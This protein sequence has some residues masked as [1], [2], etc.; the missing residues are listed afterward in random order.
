[1]G[2]LNSMNGWRNN[3]KPY[4]FFAL[5]SDDQHGSKHHTYGFVDAHQLILPA[6][7]LNEHCYEKM[8]EKC[9]GLVNG[10]TSLPAT[11]LSKQ[12]YC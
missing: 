12:C 9:S 1:M 6:K 7:N 8:F 10:P 11:D 3:L 5:F 4:E 2:N